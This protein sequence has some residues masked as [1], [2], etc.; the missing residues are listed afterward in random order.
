LDDNT[1]TNK[2]WSEVS[3][4]KLREIHL[5]EVEFLSN[6]RYGLYTSQ[7]DWAKWHKIL[8]KFGSATSAFIAAESRRIMLLARNSQPIPDVRIAAG[9]AY[10]SPRLPA[11]LITTAPEWSARGMGMVH[12]NHSLGPVLD[13][14][15]P[16][17]TLKR[18][19]DEEETSRAP[20]RHA[21][22]LELARHSDA[23]ASKYDQPSSSMP[24]I[25]QPPQFR[26]PGL[27]TANSAMSDIL[28]PSSSSNFRPNLPALNSRAMSLVYPNSQ[29][30]RPQAAL[31]P[32]IQTSMPSQGFLTVDQSN[33]L[34]P[35][36]IS[37]TGSSP[38]SANPYSNAYSPSFFLAQRSSPYRP[39]RRVQTLLVP[40][41]V[42]TIQNA[43]TMMGVN[44]MQYHTL[45]H[46]NQ[47]HL[48]HVPYFNYE[49]WP[50]TNQQNVWPHRP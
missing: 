42:Q 39:V 10:E 18:L 46:P 11:P 17:S 25:T 43:P 24:V 8:G 27:P 41:A 12:N 36:A 3:G 31:I 15:R 32:P 28:L 14:I 45:G 9:Y 49:A 5:M 1:Y 2:T 50:Q 33:Q 44:Q 38:T 22:M 4:L 48:G 21:S 13:P 23:G 34:S 6:M 20:K 7:E 47:R 37:S 30:Q 16:T 19:R 40:S 26:L 29:L 35:F